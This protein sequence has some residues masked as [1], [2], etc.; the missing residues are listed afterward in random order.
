MLMQ[1]P[2][3]GIR[4]I[5]FHPFHLH[6]LVQILLFLP[7][8]TAMPKLRVVPNAVFT[9]F[10]GIYPQNTDPGTSPTERKKVLRGTHRTI[11][12]VM[13][14]SEC[15]SYLTIKRLTSN[16]LYADASTCRDF[17]PSATHIHIPRTRVKRRRR[18]RPQSALLSKFQRSDTLTKFIH[19]SL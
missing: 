16:R 6:L 15:G 19:E 18:S 8:P 10:C 12:P 2:P 7:P 17:L 11:Q 13:V 1:R 4:L 9:D 3:T 14:E 5:L